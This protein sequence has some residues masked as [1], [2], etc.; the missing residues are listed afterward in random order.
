MDFTK[1]GFSISDN[2]GELRDVSGIISELKEIKD[3]HSTH[4][5]SDHVL[6]LQ[7]QKD[8]LEQVIAYLKRV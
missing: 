4:A 8:T 7:G 5:M 6:F 3:N 1:Y 2:Q